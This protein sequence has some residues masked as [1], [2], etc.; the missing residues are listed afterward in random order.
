MSQ[1]MV[2]HRGEDFADLFRDLLER[3]KRIHG[4]KDDVFVIAGTGST[5]WEAAIVNTLSP[6]DTVIAATNGFFGERFVSVA[7]R[8]RINVVNVEFDYGSPVTGSD[9]EE[10]LN[11]YPDAKAVQVVHNETSTG[12]LNPLQE[13]GPVVRNHDALLIVDSVSGAAGAPVAM[14]DWCCDIVFSGS[15]KA[16]MCPPGLSIIG[17]GNR[18]W[19]YTERAPIM[20]FILD[21][22]R[23]RDSARQ[24]ST[25]STAPVSL[26]Y[27]LHAACELL[28]AEGLENVYKRHIELGI[29]TRNGLEQLGL[30]IL[31]DPGYFSPTV[32][33]A[34]LPGGYTAADVQR[35]MRERHGIAIATGIS[36]MSERYI[37]IGHM[38]WTDFPDLDRTFNALEDV[39]EHLPATVG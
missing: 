21:F 37:R 33:V 28:E 17:V 23:I 9:I 16:F 32:T 4:T 25:P 19:N 34:E 29:Y 1:P 7:E 30:R 22:E 6:G 13:I 2:P 5:G 24:G 10:V 3:L 26:I 18:I 8:F 36:T 20:R 11:Q 35:M 15:Q 39:L 12:V 38:G 14:D 31:A 27:G